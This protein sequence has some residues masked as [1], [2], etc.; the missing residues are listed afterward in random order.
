MGVTLL[1]FAL[2]WKYSR[3]DRIVY[4]YE[5]GCPLIIALYFPYAK[6]YFQGGGS[7]ADQVL[8]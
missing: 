4:E 1:D 6:R 5:E 3:S 8:S 2:Y 7:Y